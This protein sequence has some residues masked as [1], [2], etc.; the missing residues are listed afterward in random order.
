MYDLYTCIYYI[1]ELCKKLSAYVI[2][3][4]SSSSCGS[5]TNRYIL[6]TLNAVISLKIYS[7]IVLTLYI[8]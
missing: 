5:Q 3:F 2:F 6:K 1:Y 4:F 8:P 7:V